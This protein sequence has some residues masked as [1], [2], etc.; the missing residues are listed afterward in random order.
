MRDN[1]RRRLNR[2]IMRRD[3]PRSSGFELR[4]PSE[5]HGYSL[6][7][8]NAAA[9][10]ASPTWQLCAGPCLCCVLT[11]ASPPTAPAEVDCSLSFSILLSCILRETPL[12][13]RLVYTVPG[14]CFV[15]SD[16]L[17]RRHATKVYLMHSVTVLRS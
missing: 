6:V 13:A 15:I 11:P 16:R 2:K 14:R 1:T 5:D 17:V 7:V 12:R 3:G 10:W 9:I 8:L 4:G